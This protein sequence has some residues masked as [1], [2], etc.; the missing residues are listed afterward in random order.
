MIVPVFVDNITFASPSKAKI[1]ELKA[2]IAKHF[3]LCNLGPTTFPLGVKIICNC[4][5]HTMHLTQHW[6]TQDLL[7]R[8]G[9]VN[10]SPVLTPMDPSVTL[11]LAHA[12]STPED[13]A[14]MQTVPYVSAVGALMYLAIV[15][16]PD[17]A[18]AIGVL[19]CYMSNPGLEHWKA[20]KHLPAA[21]CCALDN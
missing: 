7:E 6:Y 5:V 16:C 17:I 2:T 8:F 1:A 12:P 19:C 13:H 14:F 3:K 18:F 11:S 21:Y 9:F 15:T 4:P 20:V 10:S